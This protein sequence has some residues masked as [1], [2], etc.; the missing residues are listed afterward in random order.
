MKSLD[1]NRFER[2]SVLSLASIFS[3]R[4]L[5]LFM[6]LPV[7][8]LYAAHFKYASPFLIGL[9]LGVYGLTS[10]IFQA[11]YGLLSDHFGRKKMIIFGLIIF[12]LG[13]LLAGASHSIYGV[14][15]GRALQGA[16]AVGSTILAL[17]ADLTREEVRTKAMATI[18]MSIGASFMLSLALG[19]VFIAHF[20]LADIFYLTAFL[21]VVAIGVLLWVVPSPKASVFHR[22]QEIDLAS[23]K[24]I[25]TRTDLL[26]LDFAVFIL[27]AI[28][29]ATFVALPVAMLHVTHISAHNQWLVYLP[30]LVLAFILMVPMIIIA[31][32]KRKMRE[33][34][35]VAIGLLVIAELGFYF[36]SAH[37]TA[38]I[39]SLLFFFTAFTYLEGTLPSWISKVA[40]IETK[41]TAIGLYS[42]S[43]FFGAFVGGAFGG[44]LYGLKHFNAVFLF[45]VVMLCIWLL[46]VF[47]MKNPPYVATRMLNVGKQSEQSASKLEQALSKI[48]GVVQATVIAVDGIAYVK[49]DSKKVDDSKLFAYSVLTEG[50]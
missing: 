4:M 16:G 28:L 42:S 31:E 2:T 35:L 18:G 14:I 50:R 26:S 47:N 27:H 39:I 36:F 38:V 7:F 13:S 3:L 10:A 21:G 37:I 5:G 6:I 43:Q 46:V 1:I 23:L 25:V 33:V 45:C 15:A 8:S 24:A 17:L 29:M 49:V 44:W 12:A 9:A 41:G 20:N 34:T 30:V 40:P 48:K 19:P 22:D 11:P 32:K